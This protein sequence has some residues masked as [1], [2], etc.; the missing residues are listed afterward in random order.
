VQIGQSSAQVVMAEGLAAT[1]ESAWTPLRPAV[2]M[3]VLALCESVVV[4]FRARYL[5]ARRM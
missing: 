4:M 5:P 3:M 2:L 1:G